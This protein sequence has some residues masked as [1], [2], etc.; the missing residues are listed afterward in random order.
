MIG[1]LDEWRDGIEDHNDGHDKK[2]ECAI[3]SYRS[4]SKIEGKL[5][6]KLQFQLSFVN[7]IKPNFLEAINIRDSFMQQ[8]SDGVCQSWHVQVLEFTFQVSN[9]LQFPSLNNAISLPYNH[10][11]LT[12]LTLQTIIARRQH[13][14]G[15]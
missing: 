8:Q 12:Y 15:C 2:E 3:D 1:G 9:T 13:V 4:L 7:I 6:A 10:K 5:I 14:E 11:Q